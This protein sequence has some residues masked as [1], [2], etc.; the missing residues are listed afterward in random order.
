M[1]DAVV[2]VA[3]DQL[4][5]LSPPGLTVGQVPSF[6]QRV[7]SHRDSLLGKL[8]LPVTVTLVLDA[9]G[10][11]GRCLHGSQSVRRGRECHPWFAEGSGHVTAL[12]ASAQGSDSWSIRVAVHP[13][14]VLTECAG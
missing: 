7:A 13:W 6:L 9:D 2:G 3:D 5:G 12:T 14:M 4:A 11:V 1:G 8:D 10:G